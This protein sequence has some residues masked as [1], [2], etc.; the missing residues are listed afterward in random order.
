MNDKKHVTVLGSTGS[1]GTQ[2]LRVAEFADY[3]VD[4]IAFGSNTK[5][6][7]E[8]IRNFKPRFVAVNNEKA[9]FDL[10]MKQQIN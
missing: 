8:Q 2:A 4:A 1:I 7:E 10:K 9:A 5:L 3:T 6:G